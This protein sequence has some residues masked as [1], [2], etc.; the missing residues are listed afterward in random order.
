[1]KLNA[2]KIFIINIFYRKHPKYTKLSNENSPDLIWCFRFR[3]S[4]SAH[5][6]CTFV[7]SV[8]LLYVIDRSSLVITPQQC[9][10]FVLYQQ[11]RSLL[12]TVYCDVSRRLFVSLK[13]LSKIL[14]SSFDFMENT[15]A[16][17]A[18]ATSRYEYYTVLKSY[19]KSFKAK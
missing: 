1:M 16:L 9:C 18:W 4:C 3:L 13:A 2:H 12:D 11:Y 14:S 15:R 6:V 17:L 19:I 8:G 7:L 10:V 5:V